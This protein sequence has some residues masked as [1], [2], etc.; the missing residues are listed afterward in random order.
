MT[1]QELKDKFD[2]I[3]NTDDMPRIEDL[4]LVKNKQGTYYLT[5]Y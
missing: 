5:T 2:E 1:K 4:A 3:I